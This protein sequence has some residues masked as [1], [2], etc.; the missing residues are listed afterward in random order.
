MRRLGSIR[1]EPLDLQ[2]TKGAAPI[3]VAGATPVAAAKSAPMEKFSRDGA[4]SDGS[5]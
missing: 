2:P 1:R 4:C 5:S 3:T